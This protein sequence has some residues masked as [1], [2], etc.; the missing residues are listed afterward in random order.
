MEVFLIIVGIIFLIGGL[1]GCFLPVV[2]GPPMSYISLLFLHFSKENGAF[3]T[4]FLLGFLVLTIVVT[5]LDFV[6]PSVGA[7]YVGAS[8]YGTVGAF[9]GMIA[10]MILFSATVILVPIGMILGTFAGTLI[11]E[12]IYGKNH[13]DAVQSGIASVIGFVVA[14]VMKFSLSGVMAF[15]FFKYI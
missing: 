14:T 11:G 7:K 5:I 12:Y 3:S 8:R 9:I 6:I 13:K 2:P 1:I 15:F 10:G 4:S